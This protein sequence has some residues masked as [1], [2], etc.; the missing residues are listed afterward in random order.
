MNK[1][2]LLAGAAGLV[3]LAGAMP[4]AAQEIDYGS[5]QS[6]FNEPVTTSATG[7][8]Q[9]AADAPV[10]M[11][12]ITAEDIKRSGATD[13][14]TILSRVP[15]I[16]ILNWSASQSDVAVNGY[17]KVDSSR[18]LVLINGREVYLNHYGFTAWENLPVQ[19]DEIRQIEVVRGPNSA[20]FGFNAVGGVINIITYN[21][22]FDDVGSLEGHGGTQ[23]NAGGSA[24]E[25]VHLGDRLSV[26]IS[27][28][29]ERQDEWENASKTAHDKPV[30]NAR[31][32]IDAVAKLADKTDLRVEGSWARSFD[33]DLDSING[34]LPTVITTS[35]LKATLTSDTPY[36]LLQAQS[37][38]NDMGQI[39]G[40]YFKNQSIVTSV[41]DLFKIGTRNTFRVAFEYRNNRINTLGDNLGHVSYNVLSPSAMWNFAATSQLAFTV[42]GRADNLSLNRTGLVGVGI[43]LTNSDWKKSFTAFSANLGAV[44]KLTPQDTFRVAY[45]RGVQVPTL[46]E[47]GGVELT[48]GSPKPPNGLVLEGNPNLTPAVV[49]N[50]EVSYDRGIPQLDAMVGARVFYQQSTD[51]KGTWDFSHF[52]IP[53]TATTYGIVQYVKA[54]NSDMVGATL[55][56]SGKIKGGFHWSADT[57]YTSVTDQAFAGVNL[58]TR[59]VAFAQTTPKF[60]G[61]AAAGWADARWSVDAYVHYVSKFDSYTVASALAPVPAYA[62]LAGRIAY[63]LSKGLTVA[64]NGQNLGQSRQAQG[65]PGGLLAP[66]RVL[67]SL[68]KTW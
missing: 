61:N 46:V 47:F 37:Y 68:T 65:Q 13:L 31:S 3:L 40:S 64:I 50:Y 17:D 22:Q 35:S 15:G 1:Q 30:W 56:A 8:P 26:R 21:P 66:S 54:S 43:P 32:N 49:T 48:E 27:L 12:I 7:S 53:P 57:T 42:A 16:D 11:T 6:M 59:G 55:S 19:L 44:Y 34:Y 63:Q 25:T 20:L 62:S 60:R 38:V 36:G 18:L 29:G 14:P 9:R 58:V 10:D 52:D 5:L 39:D 33:N 24:V 41:Q 23:S 4:A 51:I 45:A 67:L 28:G 2:F